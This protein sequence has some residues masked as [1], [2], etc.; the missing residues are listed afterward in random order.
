MVGNELHEKGRGQPD[1]RPQEPRARAPAP[2]RRARAAMRA[3]TGLL[4]LTTRIPPC[5]D[6]IKQMVD[7]ICQGDDDPLLRERAVAIAE[8]QLWLSCIGPKSSPFLNGCE[9]RRKT[10]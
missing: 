7:A 5:R 1:Q 3:G 10:R 9:I 8:S 4:H 6:Q 2:A